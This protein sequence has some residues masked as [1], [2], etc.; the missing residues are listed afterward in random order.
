MQLI[1]S[2]AFHS[3]DEYDFC[4]NSIL[5]YSLFL[6]DQW[7]QDIKKGRFVQPD[8]LRYSTT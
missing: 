3:K 4:G 5:Q 8:K 6:Q 2:L 1:R 7:D